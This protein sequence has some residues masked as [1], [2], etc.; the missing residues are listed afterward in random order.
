M[1]PVAL[2]RVDAVAALLLAGVLALTASLRLHPDACGQC[3]DD[4][5]Y[6]ATAKALAEGESYRQ[7]FL[8]GSPPQT[9]YP[10]LY[11]VLLA[12]LWS[13][14][15]DFPANLLLLKGFTLLCGSAFL[16]T[17]SLFVVGSGYA[18]GGVALSAGLLCATSAPFQFFATVTL[19]EM[20]FA[21]LLVTALWW[22]ESAVQRPSSGPTADFLGGILLALPFLCRSV[23]M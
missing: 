14:W 12:M 16:A 13:A 1:W 21:L 20:L 4:A 3:H 5:I 8:P 2:H 18:R 6:V 11:P 22:L 17:F 19:S 7:T 9:K 15:P 10:P 23:G